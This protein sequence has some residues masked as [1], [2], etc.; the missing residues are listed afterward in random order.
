MKNLLKELKVIKTLNIATLIGA[1]VWVF[2]EVHNEVV[3]YRNKIRD[4][5]LVVVWCLLVL[6]TVGI[7][8]Y[9]YGK[10]KGRG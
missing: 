4:D 8:I 2:T 9:R 1:G 10:L 3:G 5:D 6:V 7:F